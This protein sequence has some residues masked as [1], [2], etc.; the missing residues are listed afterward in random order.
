VPTVTD[1]TRCHGA[2]RARHVVIDDMPWR[3]V[4]L[5][6]LKELDIKP[7]DDVEFD[8]L[9]NLIDEMEPRLARA[10]ALALIGYRERCA[11]EVTSKLAAEGYSSAAARCVVED[12]QAIGLIDDTRF[13]EAR[14]RTLLEIKGLGRARALR[15]MSA[16]GLDR[17]HALRALD[18]SAP[19]D[20]EL[21][22][23]ALAARRMARTSDTVNSLARR[24]VRKGYDV[25][26]ALQAARDHVGTDSGVHNEF[27]WN[28]PD[29]PTGGHDAPEE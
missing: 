5:G 2:P 4:P 14:A 15:E 17:E 29:A 10:R 7:G 8:V 27:G 3:A 22:R 26:A 9:E 12:L 28:G 11:A 21:R 18:A 16:S 23:A 1:I 25:S 24:L 19:Q 20:G 6:V 13:A